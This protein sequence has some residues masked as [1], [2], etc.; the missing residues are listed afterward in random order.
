MIRTRSRV[1]AAR[2]SAI[3][4]VAAIL[5][6]MSTLLSCG[7]SEGVPQTKLGATPAMSVVKAKE[8]ARAVNLRYPDKVPGQLAQGQEREAPDARA[9]F[10]RC[11][12]GVY[13]LETSRESPVFARSLPVAQILL[14]SKI[15]STVEVFADARV[16]HRAFANL[17]SRGGADCVKRLLSDSLRSAR[18][19]PIR[20]TVPTV[21]RRPLVVAGTTVGGL[22][23]TRVLSVS[24]KL[25]QPPRRVRDYTDEFS[26]VV[27]SAKVDLLC[28]ST[29]RPISAEI[30]RSLLALLYNRARAT[31]P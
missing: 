24:S 23:I 2:P 10:V 30:E 28:E 4:S 27:A 14:Y 5:L 19:S 13:S 6:P 7:G 1:D 11:E 16:A 3:M 20:S 8:Y 26:F 18:S 21:A 12:G 15:Y 25:F 17:N 31:T 29:V 22:R 9:V